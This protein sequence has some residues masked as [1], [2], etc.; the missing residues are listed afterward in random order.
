MLL[1][2][3]FCARSQNLYELVL[4]GRR[5]TVAFKRCDLRV[6]AWPHAAQVHVRGDREPQMRIPLRGSLR[7]PVQ[8][9]YGG[10][11][12]SVRVSKTRKC[13]RGRAGKKL[14]QHEFFALAEALKV[15]TSL[16]TLDVARACDVACISHRVV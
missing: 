3:F 7:T 10:T 2:T 5:S 1:A 4:K 12:V 15:N 9:G 11:A 14:E 16:K 8:L 13:R 6:I